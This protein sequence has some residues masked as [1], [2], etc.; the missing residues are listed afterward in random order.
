MK[1]EEFA[2]EIKG[3]TTKKRVHKITGSYG[4]YDYYKY[5]R[6]TKPKDP[7]YRVTEKEFYSIIRTINKKL[8][9]RLTKGFEINLPKR[10][11][12]VELRKYT[13]NPKIDSNGK[14]VFNAPIDWDK[15][16]KLW[17]EDPNEYKNKTL[18]KIKNKEYF[19]VCYNKSNANYENKT[20]YSFRLNRE[21]RKQ[22]YKEEQNGL[23]AFTF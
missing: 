2:K 16:I 19:K 6:K 10:M 22:L 15:T 3:V 5:Y 1:Y 11:G 20:Y 17:Y 14:V 21:L 4:V 12:I 7:S 13:I 18:I 9:E 23:D 8:G